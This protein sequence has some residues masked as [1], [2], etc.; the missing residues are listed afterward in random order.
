MKRAAAT[1]NRFIRYLARMSGKTPFRFVIDGGRP[2]H[3]R[4][5][6]YELAT[7]LW[8]GWVRIGHN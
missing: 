7:S 4:S 8:L 2:V 5:V 3:L 1:G 6:R